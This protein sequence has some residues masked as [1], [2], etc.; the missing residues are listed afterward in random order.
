MS[1][2]RSTIARRISEGA[3]IPKSLRFEGGYRED[4]LVASNLQ[5]RRAGEALP[6]QPLQQGL[7][8]LLSAKGF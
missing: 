4:V 1:N 5:R 8:A 3:Y 7:G 6:T 2:Q